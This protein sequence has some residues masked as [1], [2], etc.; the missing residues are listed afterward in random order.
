MSQCIVGCVK[1]SMPKYQDVLLRPITEA[2]MLFYSDWQSSAQHIT[3]AELVQHL[4]TLLK[5]LHFVFLLPHRPQN[6]EQEGQS[7]LLWIYFP[8]RMYTACNSTYFVRPAA[9]FTE[10]NKYV[11]WN[12]S[13]IQTVFIN[14]SEKAAKRCFTQ[15]TNFTSTGLKTPK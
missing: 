14:G 13:T 2:S 12:Q 9:V 11:I 3:W 1:C 6:Y 5:S 4:G 8:I 15:I 10:S 7:L